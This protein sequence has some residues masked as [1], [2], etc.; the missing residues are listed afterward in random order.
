MIQSKQNNMLLLLLG[1]TLC[2]STVAL[3]ATSEEHGWARPLLTHVCQEIVPIHYF[4]GFL[5]NCFNIV[6]STQQPQGVRTTPINSQAQEQHRTARSDQAD[7]PTSSTPPSDLPR[8]P[9][10]EPEPHA[11]LPGPALPP[12]IQPKPARPGL[13]PPSMPEPAAPHLAPA[14]PPMPQPAEPP[15]LS[16]RPDLNP[17]HPGAPKQQPRPPSP[18]SEPEPTTYKYFQ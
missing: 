4:D 1:A 7:P 17:A 2:P 12:S 13:P 18:R 16:G 8:P 10:P 6:V 14:P 5:A 9:D 3:A 15:P 11:N